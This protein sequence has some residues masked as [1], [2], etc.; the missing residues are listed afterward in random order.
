MDREALALYFLQP[1]RVGLRVEPLEPQQGKVLVRSRLMGISHG[2]ELLAFR[3]QM[4]P[5]LEADATLG[6]LPGT[7]EY[8][9]KYGY[10]NCGLTETG[11]RVFAFYPH[12][13]L[14]YAD[15]QE[16]IALPQELSDEEAVFLP[17]L[18]TA[19]GIVHDAAVRLGE[20]VLVA[21][22]GVVG[23]L[24]CA[25]L[26]RSGAGEVIAV[27][28]L[29]LRRESAE[30]LGCRVFSSEEP[31]L[32]GRIKGLTGGRGVDV[33]I[34]VSASESGLQL[35]LDTLA[36]EGTLVEASWFGN[37]KVSLEL[38]RSFHRNRLKLVSSQVSHIGA[39]LA[40]RWDKRR[41]LDLALELLAQ[42]RP[43]RYITQRF[44]L[45][46][47]Q[48]AFELI[49]RQPGRVIQVVLEP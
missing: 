42:L 28:P 14:F 45:E 16:L 3:G 12:Q 7:L 41:R 4:P 8:P 48:E 46:R 9:L 32:A 21:G 17:N 30:E 34:D 11:A 26:A 10:S 19:M 33:A 39:G 6:G 44:P 38:G 29:A 47:A 22:L 40:P 18:E 43:S 25:L 27:E 37:R 2:T 15:P 24:A 35:A 23:L 49:D 36:F 13:D 31:D 20:K 1:G 5:G